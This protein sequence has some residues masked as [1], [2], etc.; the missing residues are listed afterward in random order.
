[1]VNK[2]LYSVSVLLIFITVECA[3]AQFA[4]NIN[5]VPMR[6]ISGYTNVSGSPFLSDQ[7]AK[8]MVKMA[9]GRTFKDVLLKYDQLKDEL[10]FQ[11]KKKDTLIFVDPVREFKM[12]YGAGDELHEKLFRNGYK[13]IPNSTEN[14][15]FEVLS[16]GTAQLL[17][18]TTK[19]ISESKEYNSTTVVQRFDDNV[20]YYIIVSE[21]VL[22]IKKDKKSILT[23]LSNKQPQ[24]E[25]FMRTNNI[26]LK[27]DEDLSK[28][29]AYYNS[30]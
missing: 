7:W 6:T 11:D 30:L 13:N 17:K 15:F 25:S 2:F 5:G 24:L 19:S 18:R 12:E 14:S 8:G 22:P 4:E 26:N 27:N 28:L 21:R 3:H 29:M 10:Y 1:M 9:D 23:A 20:K 16:D